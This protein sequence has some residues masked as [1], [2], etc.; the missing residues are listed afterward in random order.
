VSQTG[1]ISRESNQRKSK[2]R[3]PHRTLI[4]FAC[5]P[6]VNAEIDPISSLANALHRVI[7]T[8]PTQTFNSSPKVEPKAFD[9]NSSETLVWFRE[10]KYIADS[11]GWP[12]D[13]RVRHARRKL[14]GDALN[15]YR[16]TFAAYI[17]STLTDKAVERHPTG[18]SSSLSSLELYPPNQSSILL[19]ACPQCEE[20]RPK[21]T[22]HFSAVSSWPRMSITHGC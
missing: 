12:N 11:S 6:A 7:D 20:N 4:A 22:Q 10:F 14:V 21:P 16:M 1:S 13:L 17:T 5:D 15:W 2:H 9:G 8:R 19:T 18:K 3:S